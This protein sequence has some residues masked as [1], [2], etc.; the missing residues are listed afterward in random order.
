MREKRKRKKKESL[1]PTSI[2]SR[3]WRPLRL[4][5]FLRPTVAHWSPNRPLRNGIVLNKLSRQKISEKKR[6]E[7]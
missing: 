6:S 5:R 7:P 1:K 2:C 3:N 4:P